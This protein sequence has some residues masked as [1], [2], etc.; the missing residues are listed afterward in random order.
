MA[1][2]PHRVAAHV[3]DARVQ[4]LGDRAKALTA[5][6]LDPPA[7]LHP[8]DVLLV[9]DRHHARRATML[10]QEGVEAVER[11][12]VQHALPDERGGQERD[13]VAVVARHARRIETVLG[14]ERER[15]KP[16]RDARQHARGRL[17][18][19]ADR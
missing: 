8:G 11:P 16:Q 6:E 5:L 2:Q 10:G 13:P 4:Q 19:G 18:V 17:G 3:L 7:C 12:D 15:V 1:D 14:V 9:V